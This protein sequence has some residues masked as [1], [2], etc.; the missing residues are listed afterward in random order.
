MKTPL[1]WSVLLS[2]VAALGSGGCAGGGSTRSEP[3]S[4]VV[5][6]GGLAAGDSLAIDATSPGVPFA[7]YHAS[8]ASGDSITIEQVIAAK[9]RWGPGD[10]L[11][12]RGHYRL[13]SQPAATLALYVTTRSSGRTVSSPRQVTKVASGSGEFELT[14]V[15][16]AEGGEPH[17]SFYP[18]GGGSVM[19]G[20]YFRSV[21]R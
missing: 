13:A 8:F 11:T 7:I 10:T 12:V 5:L 15:M 17:V 18:S 4:S 21:A 14:C 6:G 9:P 1:R 19:G 3:A 2:I 16:P 20:V